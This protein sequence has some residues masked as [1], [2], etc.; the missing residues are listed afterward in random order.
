MEAT[1]KASQV[2]TNKVFRVRKAS[3]RTINQDRKWVITTNNKGSFPTKVNTHPDK[4]SF[5]AVMV[6]TRK[7]N[8]LKANILKANIKVNILLKVITEE[9]DSPTME[10]GPA[11]ELP[12]VSWEG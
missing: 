2:T 6:N 5:L 12:A 1:N 9:L 4:A 8:I 3:K 10:V 7:A 11:V